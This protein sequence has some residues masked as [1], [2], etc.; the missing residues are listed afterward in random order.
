ME[1][2]KISKDNDLDQEKFVENNES[3]YEAIMVIS[4][5]SRQVSKKN[6]EEFDKIYQEREAEKKAIAEAGNNNNQKPTIILPKYEKPYRVAMTELL[7]EELDFGYIK[8]A[9]INK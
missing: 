5:R 8:L 7:N 6:H 4:K 3:I 2:I 9:D 1:K